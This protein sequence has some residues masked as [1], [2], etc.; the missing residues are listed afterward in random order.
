MRLPLSWLGEFLSE[1]PTPEVLAERLT[2]LGIEVELIETI[3]CPSRGVVIVEVKH[4][5]PHP[6]ADRLV[7]AE[8][9][10]GRSMTPVVCGA[11]NCRPGMM[12]A[13]APPGARL[14]GKEGVFEIAIAT[15]RGVESFGMLC[16]TDELGLGAGAA[17]IWE[18]GEDLAPGARLEDLWRETV[19][20]LSFTPNLGHA[21]SVLGIARE[22]SASFEIP[23]RDPVDA[24]PSLQE[25]AEGPKIAIENFHL[26]SQYHL[27]S[28]QGPFRTRSPLLWQKRLM[29]AGVRPICPVV[30][31]TNLVL[32]ERGQP[33]HAFDAARVH[34]P[35]R[36]REG[37]AGET[38]LLLDGKEV[39]VEGLPVIADEV[40]ALAV[41]GVM[42]GATSGVSL[43]TTEA[44]LECAVFDPG[45]VRSASKQLAIRSE[46]SMRFERGVDSGGCMNALMRVAELFR[47]V[48]GEVVALSSLGSAAAPRHI[49]L[50]MPWLRT[51]LG[52]HLG[53]GEVE[54]LLSRLRCQVTAD[55]ETMTVTPPSDRNDLREPIDL[56]E[57]VARL[58]G[59]DNLLRREHA[60]H[61]G[62][63]P[64]DPIYRGLERIRE[65]CVAQGLQEFLTCAL[66]SPQQ[67]ELVSHPLQVRVTNPA[68]EEHSV[69]RPSLLPG[70]IAT[71]Q[72]NQAHR[73]GSVAGFELGRVHLRSPDGRYVEP[74][75]AGVILCGFQSNSS[76]SNSPAE[77]DFFSGKGLIEGWAQSLGLKGSWSLKPS[78]H[79]L[80]HPHRQ[81]LLFWDGHE[82]GRLG[83]LHPKVVKDLD[84]RGRPI[85]AELALEHWIMAL[86][87]PDSKLK[88]P[89]EFPSTERDCTLA[90]PKKLSVSV[91]EEA[92]AKSKSHHLE[93]WS[94]TTI[95]DDPRD[96]ATRHVT[97][98]FVYRDPH[99]TLTGAEVD[100]AQA[101]LVEKLVSAL[102][103]VQE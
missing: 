40:Q 50:N 61:L 9:W 11:P 52:L 27:L 44:L 77:W 59:Y 53:T 73:E 45:R 62:T 48:G 100:S 56:V 75:S 8:V 42:G 76:W 35:I 12:T 103:S 54:A 34:S 37:R 79:P 81:A 70:L 39:S 18:L 86:Q 63:L 26:C 67:A 46:S 10:D 94:L 97:W 66:I 71:L 2:S 5:K 4:V 85:V 17:G 32:L 57:E 31:V 60:V 96:S 38:C 41:A 64:P 6:E 91:V 89:P 23:L 28:L 19:L 7:I 51:R 88:A 13:W 16:S 84:L 3:D 83:E 93:G 36:V 30:D 24:L 65:A 1:V 92:I 55:H 80:L 99:R 74:W 90:L 15:V 102:A 95:Y 20:H 68:S 101:E 49:A 22:I 14:P 58:Y 25:L 98:R 29:L 43:T 47:Q 87:A 82:V 33:L 72:T 69:L 78:S 21:M